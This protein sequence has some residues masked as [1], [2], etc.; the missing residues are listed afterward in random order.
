MIFSGPLS[1]GVTTTGD[2]RVDTLSGATPLADMKNRL[3]SMAMISEIRDSPLYG[4]I[5]G[6][7]W[8]W[9]NAAYLVG[10]I[11]LLVM[12]VISWQIPVAVLGSLFFISMIFNMYNPDVYASSLFHLFAGGSMLGAFFVATDPV[13]ASNSPRGQLIYGCIIGL[14]AYIIRVWGAYP[15]G[16]AFAVLIANGFVPLIDRHTRPRVI[17]EK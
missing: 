15:D 4:S 1:P 9:I 12:G 13:S 2:N 14:F 3:A 5:A 6:T 7:S 17:G 16:I 11:G 8:E 10:G